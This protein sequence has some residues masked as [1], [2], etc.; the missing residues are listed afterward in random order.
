[1]G[2]DSAIKYPTIVIIKFERGSQMKLYNTQFGILNEMQIKIKLAK[3]V[4]IEYKPLDIAKMA[5]NVKL[6]K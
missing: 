2:P 1:M 4:K 3:N 6:D 5:Y